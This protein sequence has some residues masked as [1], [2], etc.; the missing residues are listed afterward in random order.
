MGKGRGGTLNKKSNKKKEFPIHSFVMFLI[1][2]LLSIPLILFINDLFSNL[3][4]SK[5]SSPDRLMFI[6]SVDTVTFLVVIPFALI[7]CIMQ[8]LY[9][10][11]DKKV[12]FFKNAIHLT[13]AIL[14]VGGLL[15]WN[16]FYHYAHI[17]K[18]E[19][20]T[21]Q[22]L[23]TKET[24]HDLEEIQY[25][26]VDYRLKSKERIDIFYHLHLTNDLII[27]LKDSSDFFLR[28]VP[29]DQYLGRKGI[30][31]HRREIVQDDEYLFRENYE[32]P[33]EFEGIDRL[34]V[35]EEIFN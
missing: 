28:I 1:L 20:V 19:I 35:L 18:Q 17:G 9:I 33:G 21:R 4:I 24:R 15:V 25:V 31:I 6:H 7:F 16:D 2:V 8:V 30:A 22:G 11:W 3:Q 13:I 27:N 26:T 29:T 23:L 34:E 14:L 5:F 10:G 32:G 12:L